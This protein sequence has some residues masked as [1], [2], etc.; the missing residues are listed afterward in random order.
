M[1]PE[2]DGDDESHGGEPSATEAVEVTMPR[3]LLREIDAFAAHHGF[4]SPDAV[5]AAALAQRDE[6]PEE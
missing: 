2:C 5:V 6:E 3:E 4:E 1:M